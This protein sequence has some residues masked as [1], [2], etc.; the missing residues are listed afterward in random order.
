MKSKLKRA[1]RIF[2]PEFPDERAARQFSSLASLNAISVGASVFQLEQV[3]RTQRTRRLVIPIY[4][5]D[6]TDYDLSKL[7]TLLHDL[8]VFAL[9]EDVEI[10]F[11]E[12]RRAE[13][14]ELW[15]A[16]RTDNVCLFSGGVDSYAGILLSQQA[17]GSLEGAFCAHSDQ[18]RI[19]HIVAELQR[20]VLAAKGLTVTKLPV[21]SIGARGYAN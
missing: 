21:P 9:V 6:E 10:G 7:S 8:I 2:A 18:A 5:S 1:K 17:L 15:A 16:E 14:Q 20:K 19:I 13:Q 12:A 11:K 4:R 3:V